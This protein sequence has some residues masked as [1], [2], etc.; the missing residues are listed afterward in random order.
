M[1]FSFFLFKPKQPFFNVSAPLRFLG[2]IDQLT[3]LMPSSAIVGLNQ[4]SFR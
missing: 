1:F 4:C 3:S 2:A